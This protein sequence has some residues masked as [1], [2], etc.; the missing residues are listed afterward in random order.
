MSLSVNFLTKSECRYQSS[1]DFR[2]LALWGFFGVTALAILLVL[3]ASAVKIQRVSKMGGLEK[4]WAQMEM[5]V[6]EL[7]AMDVAGKANDKT[8][9]SLRHSLGGEHEPRCKL[10]GIIQENMHE[11]LRLHHLFIGAEKGYDGLAYNVVRLVGESVG[12]GGDMQP[13]RWK[14][15]LSAS[16]ELCSVAGEVLLDQFKPEGDLHWSFTLKARSLVEEK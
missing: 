3:V 10:L 2:K 6:G 1:I 9:R 11:Q 7:R 4:E 16:P 14:R 8:Y 12:E 15:D 5:K 13:V